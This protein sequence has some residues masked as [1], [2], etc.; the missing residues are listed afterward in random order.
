MK[1]E[2]TNPLVVYIKGLFFKFVKTQAMKAMIS[3]G[4]RVSGPVGIIASIAISKFTKMLWKA[5][6]KM[7]VR[8]KNQI[9][10]KIETAKELKEYEDKINDP[11]AKPEDIKNA[12][13]DFITK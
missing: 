13:K 7:G 3:A 2:S 8:K 6:Y 4:L 9:Q 12:G 5:L 11:N 10:E 1:K